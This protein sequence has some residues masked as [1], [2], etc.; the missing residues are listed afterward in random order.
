MEFNGTSFG[1]EE[2]AIVCIGIPMQIIE[3]REYTALCR[4]RSGE[5][6]VNTLMIGPQTSGTWVL[7]F[8]GT[9]RDVISAEDAKRIQDALAAVEAIARGEEIDVDAHFPDLADPSRLPGRLSG[10]GDD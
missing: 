7:N 8:L 1:F 6:E 3:Q 9:A 2:V 10:G 4:G 5:Q